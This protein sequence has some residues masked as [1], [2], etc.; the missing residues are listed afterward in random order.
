V[1][2][3]HGQRRCFQ[4]G[5]PPQS[6]S[7]CEARPP[8]TASERGA[9]SQ[10]SALTPAK[11]RRRPAADQAECAP[12]VAHKLKPAPQ[13][14]LRHPGALGGRT[15]RYPW[16][17]ARS[18]VWGNGSALNSEPASPRPEGIAMTATPSVLRAS[19][20]PD[21]RPS[22][23]GNVCNC[24]TLWVPAPK[25]ARYGTAPNRN[26]ARGLGGRRRRSRQHHPQDGGEGRSRD[27]ERGRY[28]PMGARCP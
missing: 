11:G 8:T 1:E 3:R 6:T 5:P 18:P 20:N 23:R 10:Q 26:G 7:R 14:G 9:R 22:R 13:S 21:L 17:P 27:Y 19:T 25:L 15:F 24:C 2:R 12:S 28:C 16:H 4:A